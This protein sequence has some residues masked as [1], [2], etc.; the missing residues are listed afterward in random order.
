MFYQSLPKGMIL[1]PAKA[2][3]WRQIQKLLH[4]F[5]PASHRVNRQSWLIAA[6]L[7]GLA[8]ALSIHLLVFGVQWL[9]V[10]VLCSFLLLGVSVI[11]LGWH[12]RAQFS[13]EWQDFWVVDNQGQI[14]A[15]AKLCCGRS[16]STLHDLLVIAQWRGKGIGTC[17]VDRI[18]QAAQKPLYL[19]CAANILP[20]YTRFGFVTISPNLSNPILRHALELNDRSNIVPMVLR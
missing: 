12:W 20:F 10:L 4:S 15:C 3:D 17:L 13:R 5:E 14:I 9:Q 6:G 1:R 8:I 2:G 7:L 11:A 18:I 16:Y 19:A